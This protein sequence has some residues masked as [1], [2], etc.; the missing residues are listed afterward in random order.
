MPPLYPYREKQRPNPSNGYYISEKYRG[1]GKASTD[2]PGT[3][4]TFGEV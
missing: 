2:E 1:K 3:F 4:A